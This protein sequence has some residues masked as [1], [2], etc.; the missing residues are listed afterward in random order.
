MLTK[1]VVAL[2]GGTVE[3]DVPKDEWPEY[4]QPTGVHDAYYAGAKITWNG[5]KCICIA[6][7]GVAVVWNPDVMPAYWQF[8]EE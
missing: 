2:E 3:P 6:P 7:E 1:R 5:K 4:V 8:V